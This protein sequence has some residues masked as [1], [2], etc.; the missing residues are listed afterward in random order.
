M[1][2]LVPE[3]VDTLMENS[4]S[5][6]DLCALVSQIT[7]SQSMEIKVERTP[8][9]K[10]LLTQSGSSC[11]FKSKK[12]FDYWGLNS[13]RSDSEYDDTRFDSLKEAITSFKEFMNN[14]YVI[15]GRGSYD[16]WFRYSSVYE[17]KNV[18]VDQFNNIQLFQNGCHWIL[19]YF[20]DNQANILEERNHKDVSNWNFLEYFKLS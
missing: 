1:K 11:Y 20:K 8:G 17:D 6:I 12:E 10:W 14:K 9:L 4:Q 18:A 7:L 3:N 16:A 5:A 2:N 13:S 19:V 15:M